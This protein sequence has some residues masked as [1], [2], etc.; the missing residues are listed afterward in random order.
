MELKIFYTGI[1]AN[2]EEHSE[3]EFL[4]IMNNEFENLSGVYKSLF[5]EMFN[6]FFD[7]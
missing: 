3:V 1:G 7:L 6:N 5:G 4:T 2:K